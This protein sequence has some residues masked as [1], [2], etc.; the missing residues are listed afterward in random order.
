MKKRKKRKLKRKRK[1]KIK[2]H[3]R[4]GQVKSKSFTV[5]YFPH[6]TSVI[7]CVSV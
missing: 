1:E 4:L 7:S 6:H 5:P 3:I 2:N